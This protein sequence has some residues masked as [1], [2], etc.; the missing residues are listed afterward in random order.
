MKRILTIA[1]LVIGMMASAQGFKVGANYGTAGSMG[2]DVQYELNKGL[3]LGVGASFMLNTPGVGLE[4]NNRSYSN[5]YNIDRTT[6][7]Y[8]NVKNYSIYA[9]VGYK[10][11]TKTVVSSKLGYSQNNNYYNYYDRL[12]ILGDNGYY[13]TT[14]PASTDFLYGVQIEQN[15]YK[16]LYTSVGYDNFNEVT[17]GL[18]FRF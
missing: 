18:L 7:N 10:F 1:V 16:R 4:D 2:F 5:F 14:E 12:R 6:N 3:N 13:F 11:K 8:K 9:L 17:L 15:I